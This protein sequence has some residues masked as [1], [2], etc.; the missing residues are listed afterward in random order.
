[1]RSL[2]NMKEIC[3]ECGVE[4]KLTIE[5]LIPQWI[6]RLTINYGF[7][8]SQVLQNAG[9]RYDQLI[10]KLCQRCN[11]MKG[12][13]INYHNPLVRRYLTAFILMIELEIN[14]PKLPTKVLVKCKCVECEAVKKWDDRLRIT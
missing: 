4:E 6:E 8:N 5:H 2:E 9:L 14:K 7:S 11:V 13:K 12:G 10:C 1:M 3:P